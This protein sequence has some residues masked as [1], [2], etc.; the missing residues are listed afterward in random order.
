MT[1]RKGKELIRE[2]DT[3]YLDSGSTNAILA[4]EIRDMDLRVICHSIEVMV[5]L[6]DAPGIALISL[7]GSYRKDAGSFIGPLAVE[8][9]KHFQIQTC[10]IGAAGFSAKGIFSSQNMIEAQLKNEVLKVS[11]RRI[12]IT[13]HSKYNL[14]AFAVFAKAEDIDILITDKQFADVKT[15]MALGIEV[16]LA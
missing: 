9:L 6:A 8:N 2:G 16:I 13:D 10:F 15:L 1:A 12:V 14:A 5:A 11:N 3:I 4:R 7:G